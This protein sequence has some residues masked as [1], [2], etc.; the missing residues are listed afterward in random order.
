MFVVYQCWSTILDKARYTIAN[1]SAKLPSHDIPIFLRL[2]DDL[3]MGLAVNSKVDDTLNAKVIRVA[4]E[5]GLQYDEMFVNK[6]CI[7][8][9]LLEV[10]ISVM[11]LGPTGCGKTTIWKALQAAYNLEKL[12]KVCVVETVNPKV[13]TR[14]Q[15][16]GY[17]TLAKD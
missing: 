14:D 17:M 11:L 1:I 4:K 6:T 16:Y 2:I 10:R 5:Q 12:E 7:F 13:L 9:V 15:L 8:Q 3:F